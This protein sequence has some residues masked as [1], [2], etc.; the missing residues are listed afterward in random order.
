MF[1]SR[2]T[3]SPITYTLVAYR[4]FPVQNFPEQCFLKM[5]KKS[6]LGNGLLLHKLFPMFETFFGSD[7]TALLFLKIRK[8]FIKETV[9]SCMICF[10]FVGEFLC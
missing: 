9:C 1:L 7:S 5:G 4:T 8:N 2:Q 6:I 10:S 3:S